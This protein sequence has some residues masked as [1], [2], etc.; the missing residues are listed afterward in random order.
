MSETDKQHSEV[1]CI[2]AQIGAEYEAA[3][4]GLTGLAYGLS[5]HAFITARM[6]HIGLLHEQLKNL[7]GNAAIA[8]VAERLEQCPDPVN[9]H[10]RSSS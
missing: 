6:E 10:V 7:V 1:A 9:R 2:L 4:Q 8:L 5:Q 3:Q